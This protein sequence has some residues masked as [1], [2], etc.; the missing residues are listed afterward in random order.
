M[1]RSKVAD[2][3]LTQYKAKPWY[4]KLKVWSKI[5]LHLIIYLGFWNYIKAEIKILYSKLNN[6]KITEDIS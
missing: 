5:Q 6:K 2:R 3:I 4:Y 1:T